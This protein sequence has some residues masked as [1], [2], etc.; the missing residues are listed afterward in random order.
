MK[1][2]LLC[3]LLSFIACANTIKIVHYNIKEMDSTKIQKGLRGE[4]EQLNFAKNIVKNLNPD[5]LSLNEIQFD[6]PNIPTKDF[7]SK[8]K[9]VHYLAEIFDM[10]FE[11]TAFFPANTGML[12]RAKNGKYI[13]HP[14]QEDREKYAD[15]VNFGMFPGQYSMAGIFKY[16]LIEV[17]NFKRLPW[18]VFNRKIDLTPYA[19]AN[20]KPLPKNMSLFDKNFTV[21][22]LN[23][24]GKEVH[25][26]L[27][28][29]VP[30]FGFG[31]PKTPNFERNRDQIQFLKW[32]L[33]AKKMKFGIQPIGGKT[34]IAMGDWNVDPESKNPGAK[35]LKSL[36]KTHQPWIKDKVI[37]YRG[38]SFNPG[39]W[40][41]QL[42]YI[43]FSKD[44][45]VK[46]AG[47]Y[48]PDSNYKDL[49]CKTTTPTEIPAGMVLVQRTKTCKALVSKEYFELISAS[50]HLPL[51]AEIEL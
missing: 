16:P 36:L 44:I 18:R 17:K 27:F 20:G 3:S 29:T 7:K 49:G 5:I 30:A 8:G 14:T 10:S 47:V 26:V 46:A 38:S 45:T 13:L 32:Y 39:G 28:H 4:N 34:F 6:F 24:E 35:V 2:L 23:I 1:T 42:D 33:T 41:A 15:L 37:T 50:D 25:I 22:T 12:S 21:A 31:N 19:D 43:L 11:S 9:N 48:D 40:T 51:W